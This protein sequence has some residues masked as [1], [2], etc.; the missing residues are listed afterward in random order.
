MNEI[1]S[2]LTARNAAFARQGFTARPMM[3]ALATMVIG[4]VDPRVDPAHVLG[5]ADGDA[6]VIRNIGGRWT[7]GALQ[8]MAAL[9]AIAEAEGGTPGPGW[10]L[11]LLQHTDCG[12]TRLGGRPDLV[13]GTFGIDAADLPSKA[14]NDPRAAVAADVAEI[15]AN[16]FLPPGLIVSGLVYDVR[17]GL[18]ETAAAPVQ[19]GDAA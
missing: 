13:A 12:I 9:R 5:L 7:P 2:T 1:V 15:R 4:C 14:V 8:T 3:P 19:L 10:N 11:V 16:P 6:L 18:I 17:T